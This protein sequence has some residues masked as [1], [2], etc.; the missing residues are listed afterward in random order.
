[1]LCSSIRTAFEYLK[2]A[3]VHTDLPVEDYLLQLRDTLHPSEEVLQNGYVLLVQLRRL[4]DRHMIAASRAAFADF[5]RQEG[6]ALT[7]TLRTLLTLPDTDKALIKEGQFRLACYFH[8]VGDASERLVAC[9]AYLQTECGQE[10]GAKTL[11]IHRL[12]LLSL[13]GIRKNKQLTW[14]EYLALKNGGNEE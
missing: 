2:A 7:Q 10:S 3:D 6:K 1:M 14:S 9:R 13:A 4:L 8:M 12:A 5:H 11:E